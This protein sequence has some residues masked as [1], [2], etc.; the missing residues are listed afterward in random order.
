MRSASYLTV[1][2][3]EEN[4]GEPIEEDRNG[5]EILRVHRELAAPKED[6]DHEGGHERAIRAQKPS[7]AAETIAA[8]IRVDVAPERLQK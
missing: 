8:R 6:A 4:G 7:G 2:D 3:R 1:F 5:G